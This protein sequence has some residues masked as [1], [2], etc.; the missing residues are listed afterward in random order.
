[1][2]T[3]LIVLAG[4]ALLAVFF[5]ASRAMAGRYPPAHAAALVVFALLWIPLA[6]VNMWVGMSRAGYSFFEELPIF[7]LI[8]GLP[9]AVGYLL[10]RRLRQP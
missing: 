8:A 5:L 10:L 3:V 2:R 7:L 6:A 1:M 4:L 9:L